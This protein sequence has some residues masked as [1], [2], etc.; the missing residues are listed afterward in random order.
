MKTGLALG[1]LALFVSLASLPACGPSYQ[2]GSGD[3]SLDNPAMS[4]GL[5]KADIKRAL[6]KVLNELRSA[7]VMN[8]WRTTNPRPIV[9][10]FPFHN[11]T[12]EHIDPQLDAILS[13]TETWLIESQVVD[14]VSRERQ[15]QMIAEVEGQR[16]AVFNQS[17]TATYGKQLGAKYFITGKIEGNDERNS[18][19]RRVQ[20]FLY[21]QVIEV[22]TALIKFQGKA[23]VTKVAK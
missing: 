11:K 20:Y 6:E 23:E 17:K 12:S 14:M 4:T 9:A 21:L 3:S 1:S 2:R 15:N 16:N 18:D 13:E 7:A 10:V 22:E 19:A 5:D 8:L